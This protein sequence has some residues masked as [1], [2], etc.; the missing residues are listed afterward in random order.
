MVLTFQKAPLNFGLVNLNVVVLGLK[1]I[2]AKD[3]KKTQTQEVIEQVYN[4]VS[5][6]PCLTKRE[7][8]IAIDISDERV[9]H[10]LHG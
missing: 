9:L 10:I 1:T 5:E 4:I 7:I 2:H 8:A 6:D 3:D